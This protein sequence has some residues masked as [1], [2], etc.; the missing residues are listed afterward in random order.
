MAKKVKAVVKL[1]LEAG[2]ANPAPPVGTA[3]GPQGIAI[4]D[5]CN[6]YN[7]RTKAMSGNVIPAVVT[8]YED[9]SFNFIL[10]QPPA[11]EF[12]K[13]ALGLEKGAKTSG[14]ERVGVLTRAQLRE[15]AEKKMPDL[16]A[17]DIEAAMK[18]IA[19]TAKNM[20]VEISD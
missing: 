14:K 3:L 13:K 18:I 7:E 11:S 15:I 9:R 19:G 4:M 6:Q 8:I 5:F 12:I 17:N 1:Q 2:K 20:G 10:K 16:N